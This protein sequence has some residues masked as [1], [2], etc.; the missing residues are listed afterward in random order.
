M[1]FLSPFFLT[2]HNLRALLLQVTILLIMA[3][4]VTFCIISGECDLSLGLNMCLA[5]IIA[6]KLQRYL[7]LFAIFI[8]VL[9]VGLL[10]GWINSLIIVDQGCKLFY[11]NIG[12]DDVTAWHCARD[13]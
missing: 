8:V 5:G 2:G 12:Y 9:L 1:P 3:F 4:G 11:H 10:I 6:I 7:P 13:Q